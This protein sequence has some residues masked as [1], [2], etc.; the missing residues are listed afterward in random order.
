MS[1][2]KSSICP[3]CHDPLF[4]RPWGV[5]APCGH[6]YHDDCWD[7]LVRCGSQDDAPLPCPICKCMATDFQPVY[8]DIEQCNCLSKTSSPKNEDDDIDKIHKLSA[9]LRQ[10]RCSNRSLVNEKQVLEEENTQL[11]N[12]NSDLRELVDGFTYELDL[13]TKEHSKLQ[14]KYDKMQQKHDKMKTE[15]KQYNKAF[16]IQPSKEGGHS[17]KDK[18]RRSRSGPSVLEGLGIEDL[19]LEDIGLLLEDLFINEK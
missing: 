9:S 17:E 3:I 4:S 15:L 16:Q 11:Q 19:G 1:G 14:V 6:P 2:N 10:L 13:Q 18:R 12:E 8:V 5:S 7:E